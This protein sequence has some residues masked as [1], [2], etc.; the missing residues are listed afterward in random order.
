MQ[1]EI[2]SL[3]RRHVDLE[4]GTLRLDPGMTKNDDGRVVYLTPELKTALVS[5]LERVKALE[6][7][8]GRIVPYVFPHMGKGKRGGQPRRDFRKAWAAACKAAGVPGRY[9]HDFRRTAVR[10]MERVGVPRSVA[11]KITGHRTESMYR[12]DA[13]VS[14]ADLQEAARKLSAT[15]PATGANS[16]VERQQ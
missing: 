1:S 7:R 4:A 11:T 5:Q 12:G 13:I 3:E 16:E 6:R 8:L 15:K 2:L 10:N 14:D 9:R